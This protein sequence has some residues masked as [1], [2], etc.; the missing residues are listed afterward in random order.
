[1]LIDHIHIFLGNIG[2]SMKHDG[3]ARFL[4]R[5]ILKDII[6]QF[7]QGSVFIGNHFHQSMAGSYGDCQ[8]VAAGTA[9]KIYCHF[10]IRI[11]TFICTFGSILLLSF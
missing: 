4:V 5:N 8:T 1:M 9:D 10:R 2:A 6:A 3:E 11:H 7:R